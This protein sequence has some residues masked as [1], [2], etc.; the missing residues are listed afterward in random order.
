M[1]KELHILQVSHVDIKKWIK[2]WDI[3]PSE[4]RIPR[5]PHQHLFQDTAYQCKHV[6]D[7]LLILVT[8]HWV[9]H[10]WDCALPVVKLV[11]PEEQVHGE[12]CTRGRQKGRLPPQKVKVLGMEP[13]ARA[14]TKSQ[15]GPVHHT[16]HGSSPQL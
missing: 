8:E 16:N 4:E 7:S 15:V 2:E 12:Y 11:K 3:I 9:L 14:H 1:N 10:P 6:D 5:V 13:S